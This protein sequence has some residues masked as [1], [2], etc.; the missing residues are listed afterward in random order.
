MRLDGKVALVTGSSQ[1]IGQ[2]IAIRFA[3]AGANVVISYHGTFAR[4]LFLQQNLK[5]PEL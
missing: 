4:E 5:R 1:G 3:E 2:A